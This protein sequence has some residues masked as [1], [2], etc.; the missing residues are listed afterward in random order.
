MHWYIKNKS[1]MS[2]ISMERVVF[3]T[4]ALIY[5]M[6]GDKRLK[7]FE[8]ST[9]YISV[10]SEIET[11]GRFGITKTELKSINEIIEDF[12][13]IPFNDEIKE[14]AIHLRHTNRLKLPDSLIAATS[15]W[16]GFP[17]VTADRDFKNIP[18]LNMLLI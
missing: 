10:F 7:I 15:I 5:F 11:K 6:G 14:I 17:F 4:N 8:T 12:T 13:I 2:G 3:D 9:V 18:E 16:I 1:V